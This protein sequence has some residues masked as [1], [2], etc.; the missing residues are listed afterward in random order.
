MQNN[1]WLDG[2]ITDSEQ[3]DRVASAFLQLLHKLAEDA[4]RD[5]DTY[6][7]HAFVEQQ[8]KLNRLARE[9]EQR[10]TVARRRH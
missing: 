7:V 9:V 8:R 3:L 2:R 1:D 6:A 5:G 10:L 4:C